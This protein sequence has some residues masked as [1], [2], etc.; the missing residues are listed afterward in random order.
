[1]PAAR[2]SSPRR[3]SS[4]DTSCSSSRPRV[5]G[6]P[7]CSPRSPP[8]SAPCGS[9]AATART[10]HSCSPHCSSHSIC[11]SDS[12][13]A[14]PGCSFSPRLVVSS[15]ARGPARSQASARAPHCSRSPRSH[16]SAGSARCGPVR[17][18]S[19]RRRRWARARRGLPAAR[20]RGATAHE[21]ARGAG[22]PRVQA[23]EGRARLHQ[24]DGR[25][26]HLGRRLELLQRDLGPAALHRGLG[27]QRAAGAAGR[28]RG[29]PASQPSRARRR[30]GAGARRRRIAPI[31][32]STSCCAPP[33]GGHRGPAA[34]TRTTASRST[35]CRRRNP[36][37]V[38]SKP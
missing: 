17:S 24:P 37:G 1:M 13:R 28:A 6:N 5:Y 18:P 30:A 31:A 32:R 23:A 33:S 7:N 8:V 12:R 38:R 9:S 27:E 36:R 3:W 4:R 10:R 29:A 19:S 35:S 2:S 16:C 26:D 20:P 25:A 21:R 15:R 34:S 11:G 14:P 22:G